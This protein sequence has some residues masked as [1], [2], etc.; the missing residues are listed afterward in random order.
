MLRVSF[1]GM[2]EKSTGYSCSLKH[3]NKKNEMVRKGYPN[4]MMV[5]REL[6]RQK[7]EAISKRDAYIASETLYTPQMIL[8]PSETKQ[9]LRGDLNAL[10]EAYVD[11]RQIRKKTLT[12]WNYTFNL[13]NEYAG[14]KLIVTELTSSFIRSFAKSLEGRIKDNTINMILRNVHAIVVYAV[15]KGLLKDN[16]FSGWHYTRVYRTSSKLEYIHWKTVDIMKDMLL[17]DIVDS[18]GKL[19]SYKDDAIDKLMDKNSDLF[20]RYFFMSIV[21]WQG[22]APVDLANIKKQDIEIKRLQGN[23]YFCWDGKRS[24]T[25]KPVKI[26]IP[27]DSIYA[28]VMVKTML[29]F[30]PGEWLF[31]ILNGLN[32]DDDMYKRQRRIG[33]TLSTLSPKLKQWFRDVNHRVVKHNVDND[34]DVPLIPDNCT[35]Y[36]GRHTFAMA[37]MSKG[38]S[39]L[40]LATL[41]GRSAN[42]LAQYI[43]QLTEEGDL[44]DAVSV[45]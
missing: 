2:K 30:N 11:D 34:T 15:E 22:L 32:N 8:S 24:K 29:M 1:N 44:I 36:T 37:Y 13:L 16:P 43:T 3:W 5:N 40:A 12:N 39:P 26:R 33:N 19:Y 4:F 45:I 35:F 10:F 23:E 38:G 14:H 41:M 6:K 17:N 42:T 31:P 25:S 27:A 28:Q 9:A 20:A 18:D 7:D 21:L